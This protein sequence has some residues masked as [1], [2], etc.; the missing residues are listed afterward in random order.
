MT[1]SN[2]KGRGIK[3]SEQGIYLERKQEERKQNSQK[4]E[5]KAQGSHS[6]VSLLQRKQLKLVQNVRG[7]G[8]N[9]LGEESGPSRSSGVFGPSKKSLQTACGSIS[10]SY[11]KT[12]TT[13]KIKALFFSE[14]RK[15]C[16][17]KETI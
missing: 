15:C 9:I 14:R 12:S 17:R 10:N 11:N 3:L 8:E 4:G 5:R 6:A 2:K 7:N 13:E 1:P 16:T